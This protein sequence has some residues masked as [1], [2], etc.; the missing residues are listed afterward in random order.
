MRSDNGTELLVASGIVS[1]ASAASALFTPRLNDAA[2]ATPIVRAL[3]ASSQTDC[4]VQAQLVDTS[5]LDPKRYPSRSRWAAAA[6]LWDAAMSSDTSGQVRDFQNKLSYWQWQDEPFPNP[7]VA[8]QQR[9]PMYTLDF[10]T[11]SVEA[12]RNASEVAV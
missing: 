7:Q 10:G 4:R 6:I 1:L 5:N 2:L 8:Y 9:R 11:M 3:P 12:N